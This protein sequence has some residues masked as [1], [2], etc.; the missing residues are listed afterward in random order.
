ML[1][2]ALIRLV[3]F[4]K[5]GIF[6]VII[7]LQV[8]TEAVEEVKRYS[9]RIMANSTNAANATDTASWN[10]LPASIYIFFQP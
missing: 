2:L 6:R 10:P 8:H 1:S 3:V 4:I 5:S 7:P 9:S